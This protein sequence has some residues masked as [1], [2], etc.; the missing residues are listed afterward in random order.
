M[1]LH[2]DFLEVHL[3]FVGLVVLLDC[4]LVFAAGCLLGRVQQVVVH[5]AALWVLVEHPV[6]S[7]L[8]L[9]KHLLKARVRLNLSP[10]NQ[11]LDLN[12]PFSQLEDPLVVLLEDL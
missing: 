3:E 8:P 6:V 2:A 1:L 12:G 9:L 4:F 7:L 11:L 10:L 5:L